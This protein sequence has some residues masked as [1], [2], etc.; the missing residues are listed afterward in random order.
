[1]TSNPPTGEQEPRWQ[2]P[3]FQPTQGE[4]EYFTPSP[5][6]AV[7]PWSSPTNIPPPSTFETVVGTLA[8]LVWPIAIALFFF[9]RVSFWPALI[10]AIIIGTVLSA[11]KKNLK[12]QRRA[13]ASYTPPPGPGPTPGPD[14]R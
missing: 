13:R 8:S 1:M 11:V 3:D 12:Q 5:H 9:T 6:Q 4:P 7:T 14:Q 2:Q 10:G